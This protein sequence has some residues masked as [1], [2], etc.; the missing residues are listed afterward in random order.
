MDILISSNL[1]RLLYDLTDSDDEV[2][3]YMQELKETG[4]Y[5]VSEKV[6]E[7]LREHFVSGYCDD[8]QTLE[9]IK[10][11]FHETGYLMDTHT[12]V[13]YTVLS[14]YG[15]DVPAVVVSTAS[16]F[17][18]C[19]SVLSALGVSEQRPGTAILSQLSD[20]TGK[21]APVPLAALAGKA[22]RFEDVTQKDEMPR[23]VQEFLC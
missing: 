15:G 23:V 6:M 7:K 1:E 9:T 22:V 3:T 10:T 4:R 11:V 16:P 18:F 2:R 17:K 19:D 13:A 14:N 20:I 8:A 12:A 5:Q 21:P